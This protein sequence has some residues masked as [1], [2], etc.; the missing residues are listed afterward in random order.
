MTTM[1]KK[2]RKRLSRAHITCLPVGADVATVKR[3]N[4]LNHSRIVWL[5]RSIIFRAFVFRIS[6]LA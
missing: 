6:T 1:A 5:R 2:H 4:R 3:E